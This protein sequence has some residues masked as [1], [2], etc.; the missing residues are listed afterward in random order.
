MPQPERTRTWEKEFGTAKPF[1]LAAIDQGYTFSQIYG[2]LYDAGMSYRES[3]MRADWR[4]LQNVY[5]HESQL[6][7]LRPE[8]QI[9]DSYVTSELYA[10]NYNYVVGFDYDY[11]DPVTGQQKTGWVG[12]TSSTLGTVGEYT[13]AA[14]ELIGEGGRYHN[15]TATNLRIRYVIGK[16]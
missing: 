13:Q 14:W 10:R 8:T 11:I 9:P 2:D 4:S 7:N 15:P 12:V 6:Q 5:A 3:R 1:Y 16:E